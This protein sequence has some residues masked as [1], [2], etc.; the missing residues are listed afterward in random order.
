[1]NGSFVIDKQALE[2]IFEA[3]R[4]FVGTD[5]EAEPDF[6]E[7][8]KLSSTSLAE[9]FDDPLV[10]AQQITTL[11]FSG[12][13]YMT[14]PHRI[15]SFRARRD[16]ALSTIA[17]DIE[18]SQSEARSL[19]SH[20]EMMIT[21]KRQWYS[22]IVLSPNWAS[23]TTI[24][25]V[26]LALLAMPP[27]LAFHFRGEDWFKWVLVAEFALIWPIILLLN[28]IREFI[29]P[30][31]IIDVGRSAE[32]GARARGARNVLFVAVLIGFAVSVAATFFTNRFK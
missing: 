19:R 27:L 14:N 13:D 9:A 5:I 30:K 28:R 20:I 3:C 24:V 25:V 16:F 10:R 17:V 21:P 31:L 12:S 23:G 7:V 1:M 22:P 32:I 8:H 18:G 15:I 29:F 4:K 6:S 26:V 11:S 2:D